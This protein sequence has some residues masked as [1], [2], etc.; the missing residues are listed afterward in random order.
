MNYASKPNQLQS[1]FMQISNSSNFLVG[2]VTVTRID[3][4]NASEP[5]DTSPLFSGITLLCVPKY[6]IQNRDGRIIDGV[7]ES[8]S[9]S[10]GTVD[11]VFDLSQYFPPLTYRLMAMEFT[12][13]N[14]NTNNVGVCRI[15]FERSSS[16]DFHTLV[17]A[18][19]LPPQF[20]YLG[21]AGGDA[22]EW[23]VFVSHIAIAFVSVIFI[24]FFTLSKILARDPISSYVFN[25]HFVIP[26]IVAAL[27]VSSFGYQLSV[28][29]S[30]PLITANLGT[31]QSVNLQDQADTF[32]LVNNI[33]SVNIALMSTYLLWGHIMPRTGLS[34]FFTLLCAVTVWIV[35]SCT[36]LSIRFPSLFDSFS[37]TFGFLIRLVL[38]DVDWVKVDKGGFT[39]TVILITM[40]VGLYWLTGITIGTLIFSMRRSV[41]DSGQVAESSLISMIR[42]STLFEKTNA[43]LEKISDGEFKFKSSYEPDKTGTNMADLHPDLLAQIA[44]QV[45]S[46]SNATKPVNEEENN[47]EE[48]LAS[49]EIMATSALGSITEIKED[50]E[51]SLKQVKSQLETVRWTVRE[52]YRNVK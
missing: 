13:F 37:S 7:Y 43:I 11:L 15:L 17:S 25:P 39:L 1:M 20:L 47:D 26:I 51:G 36:V 8:Y 38:G 34:K 4:G 3:L 45:K 27:C 29:F 18:T 32:N 16:G 49:V 44:A 22:I 33:N 24:L 19:V 48:F 9:T 23:I 46:P 10:D 14:V 42:E 21:R 28:T 12:V 40:L 41:K 6:S 30:N 5:C 50:I 2:P 52:T 31:T 35:C